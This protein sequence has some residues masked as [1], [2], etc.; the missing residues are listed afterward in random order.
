VELYKPFFKLV[1]DV[2]SRHVAKPSLVVMGDQDHIFFKAAQ[3]FAEEHRNV[4]LSVIENC[5][6]VCSIEAPEL[7]NELVLKFLKGTDFPQRVTATPVPM[8]WS[9]LKA[10]QQPGG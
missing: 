6:H 2:M 10:L 4:R 5:G 9:E 1:K 8:S 3:Q 7:F